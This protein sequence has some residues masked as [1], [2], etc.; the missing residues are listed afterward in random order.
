MPVDGPAAAS[1]PKPSSVGKGK[2]RSR[3]PC[4]STL[5]ENGSNPV[6][7]GKECNSHLK[8]FE[9]AL[10]IVRLYWNITATGELWH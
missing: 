8:D 5:E 9:Y 7:R 10:C 2:T 1:G 4:V 6:R 3:R